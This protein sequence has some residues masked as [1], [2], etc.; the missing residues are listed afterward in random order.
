[1][2]VVDIRASVEQSSGQA[3]FASQ[4]L[5]QFSQ[6]AYVKRVSQRCAESRGFSLGTPNSLYKE[7]DKAG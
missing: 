2:V 1:M 3:P 6:T 7:V 5:V 4:V